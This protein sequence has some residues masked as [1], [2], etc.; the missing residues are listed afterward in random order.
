MNIVELMGCIGNYV[1]GWPL[2]IYVAVIATIYT[3]GLHGLQLR[4][5]FV[6]LKTS[7]FFA[8]KKEHDVHDMTPFQAFINTINSNLGNGSIAGMGNALYLGGPGAALWV[9]I[10]GLMLMIIRFVEV[11]ASTVYA[12]MNRT[13][14]LSYG[15]PML[16]LQHVPGG[17]YLA[18]A[19]AFFCLMY[20][21]IG[22]NAIQTNSISVSIAATWGINSL[23][24]GAILFAFVLYI[25]CGGAQRIINISVA[26]VPIK[27]FIFVVSTT[28][29]VLFHYQSL[30]AALC[31]IIRSA[32]GLQE[33]AAGVVG[34]SF[35]HV[36]AAGMSRSISATES[37]LGSAGIVFG[38]TGND[39][40]IQNGFMGMVSTLIS[41]LVSFIVA[42]CIV[43]SGVWSSGLDGAALT[44]ASFDTVFGVYGGWI[45][46][47]LSVSFGLGVLISYVYIARSAWLFLTNNRFSTGFIVLYSGCAFMGAVIAIE[48]VWSLCNIAI[49]GILFINLYGLL[50]LLPKIKRDLFNKLETY[51]A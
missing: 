25:V 17:V 37:G 43:I 35:Q 31:L 28:I 44:I 8:E 33:F 30:Y 47:F 34:F 36:I 41:T 46:S 40:A 4:Y 16:Y 38:A 45:I 19:Y 23:M 11:Y 12:T 15:G 24:I 49:A 21:L 27:V 29:V 42:L 51:R 48:L 50:M 22:G 7:C 14:K 18:Y 26:I 6:A 20:G 13:K 32:F 9:V 1:V 39:D 3:I 2:M 5:F 10:F